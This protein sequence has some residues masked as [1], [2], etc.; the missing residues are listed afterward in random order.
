MLNP[1]DELS[2]HQREI[3]RH[4]ANHDYEPSAGGILFTRMRM[5]MQGLVRADFRRHPIMARALESRDPERI[6]WAE[7]LMRALGGPHLRLLTPEYQ[8]FALDEGPNKIPNESLDHLLDTEFSGGAQVST[9]YL[10]LFSGDY[11]PVATVTS[12]TWRAAATEFTNYSEG[13]RPQWQEDGVSGQAIT[14]SPTTSDGE[15]TIAGSANLYGAA[16]LSASAKDGTGDAAGLLSGIKRFT[17]APRAV[18]S[19]DKVWLTYS[20]SASSAT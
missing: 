10:A 7:R 2:R 1:S 12:A 19:G 17:T 5:L 20:L 3:R 4:L 6:A 11:T 18:A 9:R 8:S 14:N 16:L 15:F 13:T